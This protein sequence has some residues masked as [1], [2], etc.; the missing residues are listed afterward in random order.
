MCRSRRLPAI[1]PSPPKSKHGPRLSVKTP[2]PVLRSTIIAALGGLLFGFLSAEGAETAK[3][4]VIVDKTLVAW[5]APANLTQRGGSVLTIEKSGG[6]F[7]AIVLGEIAES[8]WMA[9]TISSVARRTTS[10]KSPR[11]RR[12]QKR[13]CRSRS[14]TAVGGSRSIATERNMPDTSLLGRNRLMPT[15]RWCLG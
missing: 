5:V 11:K 3:K 4:T 2:A 8:K 14:F 1:F 7:D 10:R 12:T 13:S 6:V 15:A 9:G